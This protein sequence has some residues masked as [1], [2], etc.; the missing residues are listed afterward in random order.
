MI[1]EYLVMDINTIDCKALNDLITGLIKKENQSS[2]LKT[3]FNID[4]CTSDMAL[5]CGAV[6]RN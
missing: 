6:V 2:S 3:K 5:S 4:V 1:E